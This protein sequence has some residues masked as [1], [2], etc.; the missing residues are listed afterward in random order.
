MNYLKE[1]F[2]IKT[3]PSETIVFHNGI[4]IKN[5][6]D[7][8]QEI[9]FTDNK[10]KIIINSFSS[11]PIHIIYVGEISGDIDL[12]FEIKIPNQKVV[13]TTKI[14]NKNPAFLNIFIKN[15][16][17][18]SNFN[19]NFL[20]QNYCSF[21]LKQ[22]AQHFSKNT[23]IFLNNKII[24]HSGTKTKL[25]GISKIELGCD[26]CSSD[27]N[28]A[29]LAA[30]DAEILFSPNQQISSIPEFA[31]HSAFLWQ[32]KQPVI[33]YLSSTG[34]SLSEIKKVLEEAFTND[35]F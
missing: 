34:L 8:K 4:F 22:I 9:I 17:K 15:T 18:N 29:V 32:A 7:S 35:I 6:S 1:E 20:I 28:F 11:L 2:N 25:Y 33:Q 19:G 13:F 3:F 27:I 5:L 26:I 31:G 10:T 21:S 16:G 14:K 30:P 23:G 12:N 24:G